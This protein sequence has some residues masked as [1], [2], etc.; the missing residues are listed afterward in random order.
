MCS[1]YDELWAHTVTNP[2]ALVVMIYVY[3][4][5]VVRFVEIV[6]LTT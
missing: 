1:I 3:V 6:I 2:V 5:V 4:G